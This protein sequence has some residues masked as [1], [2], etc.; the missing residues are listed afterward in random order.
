MK[1]CVVKPGCV[2]GECNHHPSATGKCKTWS[3]KD[4]CFTSGFPKKTKI[5]WAFIRLEMFL[6][7]VCLK[8][9]NKV[10]KWRKPLEH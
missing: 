8:E 10:A 7:N 3:E 6:Q 1:S 4:R 9:K 5:K 2:T